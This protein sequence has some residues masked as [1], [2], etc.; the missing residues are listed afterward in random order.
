VTIQKKP[1]PLENHV[2]KLN[3]FSYISPSGTLKLVPDKEKLK[4]I[5]GVNLKWFISK[6]S[7]EAMLDKTCHCEG[8]GTHNPRYP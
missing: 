7:L 8:Q 2:T 1:G 4:L 3:G 5:E 6:D